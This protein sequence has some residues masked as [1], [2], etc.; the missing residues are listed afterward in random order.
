MRRNNSNIESFVRYF[1]EG[2][3]KYDTGATGVEVE[4]FV[5]HKDSGKAVTYGEWHGIE[6][7]LERLLL[8]FPKSVRSGGHLIGLANEQC[9]LSVEP[10][11]QL[12]ISI[13]QQVQL[14]R[15]EQIYK[16]SVGLIEAVLEEWGQML[17][18]TGYYPGG[19]T[20]ELPLIPKERYWYMNRY[21]A[22]YGAYGRYM[23]RGTAS[24]QVSVDYRD[25]EDFIRSY[26]AAVAM[27]PLLALLTDN[28]SVFEGEAWSRHMVRTDIW[29]HVDEKRC[30]IVPGTFKESFGFR[31]YG[32]YLY[33]VPVIFMK[34]ENGKELWM[35]EQRLC[36]ICEDGC[37]SE[38]QL[39]HSISIVFP[40]VRLKQY[41]E[42][43]M[44]DS[45]PMEY[46][47]SYV[48]MV[49]GMFAERD[50]LYEL[51]MKFA[52]FTKG[53]MSREA[54]TEGKK[55]LILYGYEGMIFG[56]NAAAWLDDM[57]ELAYAG[58]S[59][60]E[61]PYLDKMA[62][63]IRSRKSVRDVTGN[64]SVCNRKDDNDHEKSRTAV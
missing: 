3:K 27:G 49:K 43:R 54:V 58:L 44:G 51:Y 55:Q 46:M 22:Q 41:L 14:E 5:V 11:A 1:E 48:A 24:V 20:E 13:A 4:H 47:C 61:Q 6:A 42:L 37:M 19:K 36:D 8:H 40:D 59:V 53:N 56:R 60:E 64:G 15:I 25:E 32:E 7:L 16:E 50:K 52:Q 38:E 26:R 35:Q 21:F 2:C 30:G 10:A 31:S 18:T 63:L 23:M 45:M 33:Q 12:E 57:L 28:A 9:A 34:D 29:E 62:G 17:V 39:E